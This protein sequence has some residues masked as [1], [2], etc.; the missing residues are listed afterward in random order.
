MEDTKKQNTVWKKRKKCLDLQRKYGGY[1]DF[2]TNPRNNGRIANRQ[3]VYFCAKNILKDRNYT[4]LEVGPGPG[5]FLWA[6]KDYA[7]ELHGLEYSEHMIELCETQFKKTNKKVYLKQGTCWKLPYV[8]KSFDVSLQC[9]ICRHIGGCWESLE[10]QIRVS[11]KYVIFSGPSFERWNDGVEEKELSRLLFGI[12]IN[13]FNDR[14]DRMKKEG[15][16][17]NYYY[18]NRP[19]KL[20]IIKRKILIIECAQ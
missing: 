9:D 4:L 13:V 12:N 19:N 5:H 3:C 18:E 10:E 16:I 14:L 8:D 1:D 2:E 7:K 6:L 11:R 15:S 20:D 17:R